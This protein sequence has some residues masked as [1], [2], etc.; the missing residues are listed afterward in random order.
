M[1]DP[2]LVRV[3]GAVLAAVAAL[4]LSGQAAA[5]QPAVEVDWLI[6]QLA[7]G[8]V[9]R[10]P[11]AVTSVDVGRLTRQDRV[12]LAPAAGLPDDLDPLWAWASSNGHRLT[13]VEGWWI[14]QWEVTVRLE[15]SALPWVLSTGEVTDV[16]L[17]AAVPRPQAAAVA[18]ATLDGLRVSRPRDGV[19]LVSLPVRPG[20]SAGYAAA[21]ADRYPGELVVVG[22]GAWL[23][24]AGPGADRAAHARDT[25][26][27]SVLLHRAPADLVVTDLVTTVLDR[28]ADPPPR[29]VYAFP[30]PRSI[31]DVVDVV[32]YWLAPVIAGIGVWLL[33]RRRRA[34][35]VR[36][37]RMARAEAYAR[38]EELGARLADDPDP[39]LAERY[40][41][42]R[43]LFGQARTPADMAAA[44]TTAGTGLATSPA[45]ER[46]VRAGLRPTGKSGRGERRQSTPP[47]PVARRDDAN[48]LPRGVVLL[49]L[50]V[51][52]AIMGWLWTPGFVGAADSQEYTPESAAQRLRYTSVYVA[53][54]L[55]DEKS[56]DVER[57]REIVGDRPLV[58]VAGYAPMCTEI[59]GELPD[60]LVVVVS[61]DP[62]TPIVDCARP[63][64]VADPALLSD[65]QDAMT[66]V[67][68]SDRR[69]AY[70]TEYVRAFDARHPAAPHRTPPAGGGGLGAGTLVAV[71]LL[72]AAGLVAFGAFFLHRTW[73]APNA[74]LNRLATLITHDD[75]QPGRDPHQRAARA[76]EYLRTLRAFES[77]TT[78]AQRT[79]VRRL[80]T[81]LEQA[82]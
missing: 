25:A 8:Q 17:G 79:E 55:Y 30:Q 20:P 67:A 2:F 32:R 64:S 54:F 65:V 11:G 21:L 4:S 46:A 51:F 52:V 82:T 59:A 1:C 48:R 40:A 10:L 33:I 35:A 57:A 31:G 24:F 73:L 72:V 70:V 62:G 81:E 19:R 47:G 27:G 61:P 16:V 58:V 63:R 34:A 56:F 37:M 80:L 50:G 22:Y 71:P 76:N 42:A 9:V 3:L 77:A 5:A 29:P 53:P 13:V 45:P 26:Y 75:D 15:R 39:V 69:T 7:R 44:R 41:T 12:V 28:M 6:S 14:A 74:R 38:I 43:T 78:K 23:E 18:T 66:F 36:P 68:A 60:V 49:R